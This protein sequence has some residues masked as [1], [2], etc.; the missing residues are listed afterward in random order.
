MR[1]DIIVFDL[2]GTLTDPMEGVQRCMNHALERQGHAPVGRDRLAEL[3]GPPLDHALRL[4]TG[5]DEAERIRELV[6]TY[7]ERYATVGYAENIVYPGVEEALSALTQ[8]GARLG[9]CT[10]KKTEF[11]EK[12]LQHF[13]LR[14]HFEFVHGGEIGIEKWQQLA[15]LRANGRVTDGSLM[16]GDRAVDLHAAHRNGLRAS[17]VLW[18][19]GSRDELMQAQPMQLFA[20]PAEWIGLVS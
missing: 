9:V 15:E 14:G 11:A 1:P 2:D 20:S 4:L 13:G 7:R 6:S 17:G 10:S 16:I 12:I 19:Y 18:G 8:A 5:I 3:L